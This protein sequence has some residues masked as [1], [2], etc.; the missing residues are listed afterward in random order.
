MLFLY[1]ADSAM[2]GMAHRRPLSNARGRGEFHVKPMG[3]TP[4]R[5]VVA[6][7]V[8]P[9][10]IQPVA[11]FGGLVSP[12]QVRRDRLATRDCGGCTRVFRRRG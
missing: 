3:R 8:V 9:Q 5:A 12:G 4:G 6:G 1:M 10:G 7:S 2:L 11:T